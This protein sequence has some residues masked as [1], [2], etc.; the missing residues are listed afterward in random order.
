MND[1]PLVI[2]TPDGIEHWQFARCLA[3]L[4]LEVNTG[5]TMSR[6]SML[7]HVRRV[8]GIKAGTKAVA[9]RKMEALYEE[10]YGRKYG[11]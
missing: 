6:G 7:A 2:D 4:K 11:A 10:K 8:Y 9:L 3:A 1:K 5:M